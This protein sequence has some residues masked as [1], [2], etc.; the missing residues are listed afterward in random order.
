MLLVHLPTAEESEIMRTTI[1]PAQFLHRKLITDDVTTVE[2]FTED[3]AEADIQQIA[4][5]KLLR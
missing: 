4:Y 5:T 3:S 2:V 1:R